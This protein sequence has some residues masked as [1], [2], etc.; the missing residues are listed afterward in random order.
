MCIRDSDSAEAFNR[1][2]HHGLD[3]LG[4]AD[5]AG[6]CDGF[7]AQAPYLRGYGLYLAPGAG[8]AHHI[9]AGLGE[10]ERDPPPNAPARTRYYRN[11]IGKGKLV[12]DRHI[13]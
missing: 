12:Q 8:G 3:L 5:V 13:V 10:G 4:L 11:L 9:G 7:P 1:F 2:R 6:N